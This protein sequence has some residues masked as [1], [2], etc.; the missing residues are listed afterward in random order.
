MCEE[1]MQHEKHMVAF[2][3]I[4]SSLFSLLPSIA[5][6]LASR[7]LSDMTIDEESLIRIANNIMGLDHILEYLHNFFAP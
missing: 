3:Y 1:D 5:D 4:S 7:F 6:T 2:C